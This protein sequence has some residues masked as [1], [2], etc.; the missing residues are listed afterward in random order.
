[1]AEPSSERIVLI[2]M[3]GSGKTTVGRLLA[4]RIGW[5]YVDNDD[6]V[7]ELSGREPDAIAADDGEDVLHGFEAEALLATLAGGSRIVVGAAAWVVL[8]DASR[9]ALARERGVVY[10]RARP[11]TLRERIGSGRGRRSD[12][13]DQ[14]WLEDRFGERDALYRGLARLT[15]EVDDDSPETI[16]DAIAREL[17]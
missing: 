4:D 3:M 8:H 12:A 13:T 9:E 17:S 16:A 1:M 7:L 14:R 10:L 11:E 15:I 5:R 2:G 6:I